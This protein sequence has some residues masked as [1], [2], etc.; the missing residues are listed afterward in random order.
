VSDGPAIYSRRTDERAGGSG[1][2]GRDG[3]RASPT[4]TTL[5]VAGRVG[6]GPGARLYGGERITKGSFPLITMKAS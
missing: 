5:P 2:E 1:G 3:T 6:S 4:S